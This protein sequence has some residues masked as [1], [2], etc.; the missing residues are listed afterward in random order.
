MNSSEKARS[1]GTPAWLLVLGTAQYDGRP[2]PHFRARLDHVVQLAE[3]WSGIP[4]VTVGG[5]MPV[6]RFTEAEAGLNYL[7]EQG[8]EPTRIHA[9]GEGSD[10]RGSL[11]AALAE[12]PWLGEGR[13]VL[14]SDPLHGPRVVLLARQLGIRAW[15]DPTRTSPTQ[16]PR[17]TWWLALT[18]EAGGLLVAVVSHLFGRDRADRLEDALRRL[19]GKIRPS[20]RARHEQLRRQSEN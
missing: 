14:I 19:Q 20:R 17:P 9:V 10:S 6:D 2:S 4:V 12:L 5:K 16:F 1:S 15:A 11:C 13:G 18:H 3:R 8:V 7:Q